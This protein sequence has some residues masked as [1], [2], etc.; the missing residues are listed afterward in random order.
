MIE[1]IVQRFTSEFTMEQ[2][3]IDQ[4]THLL[5]IT[6]CRLGNK[7]IYVHEFDLSPMYES[8][9]KRLEEDSP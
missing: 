5:L 3:F 4:D 9:R 1:K 7:T 8:F 2:E 6:T